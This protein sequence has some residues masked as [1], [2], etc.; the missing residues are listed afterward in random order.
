MHAKQMLGVTTKGEMTLE[1]SSTLQ[2]H[3]LPSFLHFRFQTPIE[4]RVGKVY[5]STNE[6]LNAR[7][8][9]DPCRLVP[10]ILA[11]LNNGQ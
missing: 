3:L 9:E 5:S 2:R 8:M 11:L 4:Y 10:D 1:D 6:T 7:D